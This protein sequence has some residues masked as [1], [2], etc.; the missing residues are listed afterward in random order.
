MVAVQNSV[1]HDDVGVASSLAM[2]CRTMGQVIGPAFASTLWITR[3]D[4]NVRRLVPADTLATL[5]VEDLRNNSE[6]IKGLA[7]PTHTQVVEALRLAINSAFRFAAA[8]AA[9]G[10]VTALFMRSRP[11]RGTIRES[12]T[13]DQAV[14]PVRTP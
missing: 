1:R 8:V 5:D 13:N 3:F 6:T 2:F 10:I 14:A 7:E 9:V 11:L 4:S 12:S